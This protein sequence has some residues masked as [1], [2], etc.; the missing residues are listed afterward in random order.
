M[1]FKTIIVDVDDHIATIQLNRPEAMNA[2][3]ADD[4]CS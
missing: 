4:C 2:I 1:A 3:N